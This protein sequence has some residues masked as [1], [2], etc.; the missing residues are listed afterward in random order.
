MALVGG[1]DWGVSGE[2]VIPGEL[3]R[4]EVGVVDEGEPEFDLVFE[5]DEVE[6]TSGGLDEAI[7]A[8][9]G[10]SFSSES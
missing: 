6:V 8:T 9:E 10:D 5:E 4:D 2:K 3:G 1:T 7:R